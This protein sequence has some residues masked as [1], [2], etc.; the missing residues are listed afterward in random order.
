LRGSIEKSSQLALIGLWLSFSKVVSV[1]SPILKAGDIVDCPACKIEMMCMGIVADE[2][3]EPYYLLFDCHQCGIQ[4]RIE[5][6]KDVDY[7]L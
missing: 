2:G 7:S 5:M 6:K 3:K 1:Y 4:I